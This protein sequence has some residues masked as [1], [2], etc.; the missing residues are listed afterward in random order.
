MTTPAVYFQRSGPGGSRAG[1][2]SHGSCDPR[3][4]LAA[5]LRQRG[6]GAR[7]RAR[8][9]PIGR[10]PSSPTRTA[11]SPIRRGALDDVTR[12]G[13]P[14][15]G[16]ARSPGSKGEVSRGAV[17]PATLLVDDPHSLGGADRHRRGSS[18]S[19]R[20]SATA[21]WCSSRRR[22]SPGPTGTGRTTEAEVLS[23]SGDPRVG[24]A[25][26]CSSRFSTSEH[27]RT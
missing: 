8:D 6:R 13:A 9:G 11:A 1:S 14:T 21:A 20:C 5:P 7:R 16:G 17:D 26:G 2:C 10:G 12:P 25:D 23:A 24:A 15:P 22:T 3:R 19:T 18:G 27:G 4:E